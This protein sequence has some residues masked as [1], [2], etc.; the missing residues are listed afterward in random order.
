MWKSARIRPVGVRSRHR[1]DARS[2]RPSTSAVTRSCS[3]DRASA[4]PT[5]VT[6]HPESTAKDRPGCRS[7]G[8]VVA[9][10]APPSSSL[11]WHRACSFIEPALASSLLLHRACSG[12]DPALGGYPPVDIPRTLVVTNDFPPR[13]GGI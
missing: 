5:A 11:L 9:V 6:P 10:A 2:G 8:S 4:P 12:I 3:H 1:R 7:I 13:V